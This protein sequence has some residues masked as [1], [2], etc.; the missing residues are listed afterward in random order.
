MQLQD[1]I[2]GK[3][4]HRYYTASLR[5]ELRKRRGKVKKDSKWRESNI[6]LRDENIRFFLERSKK[7]EK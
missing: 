4:G 5:R 3:R 2:I 1:V 6:R 7:D